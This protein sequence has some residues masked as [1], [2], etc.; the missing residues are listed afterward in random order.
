ME[1]Q[2]WGEASSGA[3]AAVVEVC[4]RSSLGRWNFMLEPEGI[5]SKEKKQ[6]PQALCCVL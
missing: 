3:P 5:W 1:R 2:R 4:R 6:L